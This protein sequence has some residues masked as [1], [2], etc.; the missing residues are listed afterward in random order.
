MRDMIQIFLHC[1][2]IFFVL[3]MMGYASFL[4]LSVTVGSASL[5]GAKRR[6]VLKN[7]LHNGY[8]VPVSV[9]VPAYNE[10]VTIEAS[11]RSLLALDYELYEIVVVDDG[12]TDDTS[13][14]MQEAFHMVRINRP[15]Q[16]KLS[17]QAVEAVFETRA[18]KVPITLIRKKNGGKADALNMGINACRYPYFLCM[19]ADSVL[20]RDSL[21]KIVRPVLE[22]DHVVA[23]GG[24][25]RPCNGAQIEDGR[26]VQ[27]HMPNRIL[28]CMQVLEYDRSFLAARILF[29]KFNGSLIISG[30]FGLFKKS[31][32]IDA[33]G[34]D[35]TTMGEDMELVVKLHVFC[36]EHGI[37]YRIRYATD[38][39]CWTQAPEKMSDLRK[40]RQ[41]WHIGLCQSMVRH[42]SILANPKYGLV[43]FFSYFYFLLFEL[44]SPYIEV[45][46][47]LTMVLASLANLL[48]VHFMLL[49]M[50]I[51]VVYSAILSL[52]AFFARIHTIDLKLAFV[53]AMKAIGLCILEVSCLRFILAWVRMTALIGYRRK[54]E[55]WGRIERK[56]I[57]FNSSRKGNGSMGRS[58]Q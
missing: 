56:R 55:H 42:R 9:I 5:Y 4:F 52:T 48:N 35:T 25:V 44:L 40:Q 27:Y 37:A 2:G 31:A 38:A 54:K 11:I 47:V 45:F 32:V 58:M 53:D 7:E 23:V 46:G 12:S 43:S 26:V 29:D 21:E 49:Y 34:Y 18:H 50:A 33:G 15:I 22:D 36:R 16:R 6:N 19:D 41:R 39:I 57:D 51:Y 13:R 1:V 24:A 17:C 20:Q 8:Y 10:S 3:Y 14:V 30:A 28:A